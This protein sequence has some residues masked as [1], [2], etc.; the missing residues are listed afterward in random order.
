LIARHKVI[1][2]REQIL[3]SLG[4]VAI[5]FIFLD[6]LDLSVDLLP[7]F[8]EVAFS[9]V[10]LLTRET[11]LFCFVQQSFEQ[12]RAR[13]CV[14]AALPGA[15]DTRQ[16]FARNAIHHGPSLTPAHPPRVY[17]AL[18]RRALQHFIAIQRFS[19][20]FD[21]VFRAQGDVAD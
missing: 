11:G 6:Q 18:M 5:Q 17:D 4:I 8:R 1:Q 15:I 13:K 19:L 12:H 14:S 21:L 2:H 16:R 3:N 9:C 10:Q 7:K 20:I